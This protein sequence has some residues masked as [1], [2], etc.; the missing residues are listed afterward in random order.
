MAKGFTRRKAIGAIGLGAASV[1]AGAEA[2]YLGAAPIAP[3]DCGP[4]LPPG[5][6]PSS[7]PEASLPWSLRAGTVNDVSCLSRTPV[8]G[9]IAIK[10]E[11]DIADALSY[12]RANGLKVSMAGALHSMGGHAFARNGIV[13]DMTGFNAVKVDEAA[14]AMTV[15]SGARWHDIQNVL[16]PRF[17]VKAMQSSDVFTVGGSIS[18]N[19][20]G[21][22]HQ[23]GAIE[24]TL[25]RLRVMLADGTVVTASRTENADLYRHVVGGYGL[26]G[27]ILDAEI[28]IADNVIYRSERRLITLA[29]FPKL[30]AEEI[31]ADPAIGLFYGHLSTAPGSF[32]DEMLIYTYHREDIADPSLPPLAD[33]SSAGLRRFIFNLAKQGGLFSAAKW[34]AEKKLEHRFEPCTVS[35]IVKTTG[36][37]CLVSR[38]EPMH[39]SVPYLFNKMNRETDILHE[40]FVPRANLIAFVDDMRDLM[41]R[42]DTLLLNASVRVVHQED[43]ALNYAPADAFSVVLY[44]NQSVDDTGIAKMRTLTRDLIDLADKHGGRFFLP[45]QRH[46]DAAQLR[47][48]Y[49]MIAEVFAAKKRF[50]PQGLFS[51]NFYEAYAADLSTS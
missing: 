35:D 48:A 4:V 50:D 41:T 44:V 45:Y 42:Q 37:A 23:V 39:D 20:H 7:P 29:E 2:Y 24:R 19:A 22:D 36:E 14:C 13:L 38:N 28:E 49:P 30:F 15:E 6:A 11:K 8:K 1:W 3:K 43:V 18:V 33:V 16:H 27:V 26:F 51:N 34:Y 31:A 10:S 47:R 25:K 46:Y 12:A 17:A 21:M 9:V 40:Y 5:E 32:L